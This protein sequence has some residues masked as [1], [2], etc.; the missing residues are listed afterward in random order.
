M[1]QDELE[2]LVAEIDSTLGVASPRLPWVMSNDANQRQLLARARQALAAAKA[3]QALPLDPS[4]LPNDP[5]AAASSQV[6]KAL[7]QEMQYL[8]SQTMQ[9][10]DPLRNEVATLRQQRE[11]L[12]QEVQQLQQ[13]RAQIDQGATLH[14]LPP[15]WEAALQQMAHQIEANLSAQVNQSVQRLES[16]TANAYGLAQSSA[17]FSPEFADDAAP[18]FTPVQR[19]EFLK[20]LQAQ[21]DQLMLGLDQS[22]RSVFET[23]QQSIYSYQNSLNQ[24]LNQMH[25]LGQQGELMFSALVNHLGQQINP[26]TLTYLESGQRRELPQPQPGTSTPETQTGQSFAAE[27]STG[28]S[29]DLEAD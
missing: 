21:S 18:G 19:L 3:A 8:R 29:P 9:I 5:T 6:L 1:Q 20:Q 25:T 22:L 28:R 23:L 7:L 13:Q 11:L 12:L 14:Q 27:G 17:E 16:S 24:G 26:E 15:S 10:L 4:G 2:A